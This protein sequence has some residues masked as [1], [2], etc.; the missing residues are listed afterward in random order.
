MDK[1]RIA[2][3]LKQAAGTVRQLVGKLLGDRK[4]EAEGNAQKGAGKV[5]NAVGGIKDTIR[6]TL[7]KE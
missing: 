4:T 6:K 7:H 2:G 3:S 1:D 5:Q